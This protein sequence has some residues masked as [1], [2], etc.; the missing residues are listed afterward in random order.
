MS[1][2]PDRKSTSINFA[3]KSG[4]RYCFQ[5]WPL[6]TTLSPMGGGIFIITK[7]ECLDRTFPT[8]ASHRCLVIGHTADLAAALTKADLRKLLEQ[9][10]NCICVYRLSSDAERVQVENDLIEGNEHW[11]SGLQHL[12]L[13]V[14]PPKPPGGAS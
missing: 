12:V 11:R 6:D 14:V 4:Q 7:R 5:A 9:G 8:K 1:D 3:G 13:P 2:Q 10:A